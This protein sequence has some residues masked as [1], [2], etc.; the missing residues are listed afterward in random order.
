MRWKQFIDAEANK[1]AEMTKKFS[2]TTGIKVRLE[3]GI[4]KN[5]AIVEQSTD[6]ERR[7]I[8]RKN[9]AVLEKRKEKLGEI[10]QFI[11][12]AAGQMDLIENSFRLLADQIVTMRS[13]QEMGGQLDELMDGVE[14]VQST[15]RETAAMLGSAE[16]AR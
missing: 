9:L 16:L 5:H 2:E 13:V 8:A 6:E 4:A 1:F 14:A 11:L 3:A 10:R 12:K 15:E 7:D